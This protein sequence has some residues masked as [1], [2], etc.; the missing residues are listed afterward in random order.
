MCDGVGLDMVGSC[1]CWPTSCLSMTTRQKR[2]NT[3][4]EVE[5]PQHM[6]Y[7]EYNTN[8]RIEPLSIRNPQQQHKQKTNQPIQ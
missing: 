4:W 6:E 7:C 5:A 1:M 8:N 2:V 3:D